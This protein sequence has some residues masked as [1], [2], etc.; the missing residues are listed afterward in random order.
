MEGHIEL[1]STSPATSTPKAPNTRWPN[2]D[3]P[4]TGDVA[5][6]SPYYAQFE[7]T[8]L[9]PDRGRLYWRRVDPGEVTDP[10]RVDIGEPVCLFPI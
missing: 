8:N 10:A 7:M 4:Q 1:S 2:E 3:Y 9:P 6:I 5:F